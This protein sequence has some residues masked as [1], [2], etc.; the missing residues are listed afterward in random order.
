[1]NKVA[2]FLEWKSMMSKVYIQV[3][4]ATC[5]AVFFGSDQYNT[6]KRKSSEKWER[7]ENT[8]HVNDIRW[9]RDGRREERSTFK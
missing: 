9:M 4:C 8:Y 1:M 7:P 6:Q 3:Y 2:L 5:L